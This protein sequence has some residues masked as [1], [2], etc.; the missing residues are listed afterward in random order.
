M[1]LHVYLFLSPPLDRH[2]LICFRLN[3]EGVPHTGIGFKI[4]H[5]VVS[6]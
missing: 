6:P 2:H 3:C 4:F 5:V 1:P